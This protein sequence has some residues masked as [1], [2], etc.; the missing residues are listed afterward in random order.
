MQYNSEQIREIGIRASI[1]L[2]QLGE[3]LKRLKQKEI[4]K[5]KSRYYK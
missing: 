3:A 5:P 1:S 4:T 2:K